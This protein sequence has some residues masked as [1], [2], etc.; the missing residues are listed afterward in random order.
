MSPSLWDAGISDPVQIPGAPL[1]VLPGVG[2][3]QGSSH[4]A[5]GLAEQGSGGV[6]GLPEAGVVPVGVGAHIGPVIFLGQQTLEVLVVLSTGQG[7][8]CLDP[9]VPA[10]HLLQHGPRQSVVGGHGKGQLVPGNALLRVAQA[11]EKFLAA[12]TEVPLIGWSDVEVLV[13]GRGQVGQAARLVQQGE[14]EFVAPGAPLHGLP[15]FH[16]HVDAAAIGK[17]Q[18]P[19]VTV[20]VVSLDAEARPAAK[21]V[22]LLLLEE[23]GAEVLRPG[24]VGAEALRLGDYIHHIEVPVDVLGRVRVCAGALQIGRQDPGVGL[25]PVEDEIHDLLVAAHVDPSLSQNVSSPISSRAPRAGPAR[26]W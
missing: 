2:E 21:G 15:G 6:D 3:A 22:V 8:V 25:S 17:E 26:R 14:K 23:D 13:A 12:P 18:Q 20:L 7:K 19:G 4:L 10:E 5:G 11:P 24:G 9:D 16:P 1:L